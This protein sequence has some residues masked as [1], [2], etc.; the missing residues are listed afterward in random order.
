[1]LLLLDD[2]ATQAGERAGAGGP[3]VNGGRDAARQARLVGHNA[4]VGDA[5]VHVGMEINETGRHVAPGRVECLSRLAGQVGANRREPPI[6]H[7]HVGR[8]REVLAGIEYTFPPVIRKSY[9]LLTLSAEYGE[10]SAHYTDWATGHP[11]R[12]AACRHSHRE[13]DA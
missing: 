7:Q 12:C 10:K 4:V 3:G 5:P 1:M 6:L 13:E 9:T 8:S 11:A 2:V